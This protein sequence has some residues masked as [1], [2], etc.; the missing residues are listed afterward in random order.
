VPHLG[1]EGELAAT[2]ML[3]ICQNNTRKGIRVAYA[4]NRMSKL[5]H[6]AKFASQP[7]R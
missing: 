4:I 7:N 2:P 3:T 1:E 5:I 6:T